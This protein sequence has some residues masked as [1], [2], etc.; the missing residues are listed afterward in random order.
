MPS[1]LAKRWTLKEADD[2]LVARQAE[3][4][5]ISLLLARLLVLRGLVDAD[6]ARP[7]LSSSLRSDLPSPFIMA[8]M[9]PAVERIITAIKSGEQIGICGDFDVDRTTGASALVSFLREVG[10]KPVCHVA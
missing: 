7:Y 5:N 6:L 8:D 9:E 10:R 2:L 3:N 1:E 4:L